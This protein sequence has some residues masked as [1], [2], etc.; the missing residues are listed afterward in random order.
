MWSKW[1]AWH[2][3]EEAELVA[4]LLNPALVATMAPGIVRF[5]GAKAGKA[6]EIERRQMA[7]FLVKYR[8]RRLYFALA[9]L[10][11]LFSV[12]G[13]MFYSAVPK[14]SLLTS[15]LII[16]GVGFGLVVVA[17]TTYFNYRKLVGRGFLIALTSVFLLGSAGYVVGAGMAA[18]DRGLD[19]AEVLKK[20]WFRVWWV[21][22]GIGV[23][24]MLPVGAVA[25][26]RNHQ[27][28]KLLAQLQIDSERERNA[29]Q[30]SESRL[31]LLHAQIEPHFLFNTLGAV[32]QLAERGA[33][34][35]AALTGHLIDFLRASMNQMRDETATLAGD[36]ELIGAYLHV[37]QARL[38][39]RLR[40]RLVLPPELA[41]HAVPSMLLL[42]L[43]ENA[44]KHGIEPALRGGE[45]HVAAVRR[46]DHLYLVVCDS[47]VGLPVE[48][49]SGGEGL[50]NVR[51]RLQLQYGAQASFM[52][53][54]GP[55]GGAVAEIILPLTDLKSAS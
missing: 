37:M 45:I 34:Q 17:F 3:K 2:R 43:V 46:D 51:T 39:D 54:D 49:G 53:K 24:F 5:F 32:Q 52:L 21:G 50:N 20:K 36:F 14:A 44:V 16:N 42:T 41:Q 12:G 33:P 25:I 48:R 4:L 15:L 19:V 22:G 30:L 29:R 13:L 7:E 11:L 10:C 47:G 27:Y 38:G 26:A 6:S 55:E 23:A 1:V 31:R 28:H 9:K 8:G 18:R 35:A 40:Y